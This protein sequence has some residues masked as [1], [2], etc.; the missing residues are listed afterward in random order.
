MIAYLF[1]PLLAA[2]I[3]FLA[4]L[5]FRIFSAQKSYRVPLARNVFIAAIVLFLATVIIV[6]TLHI[7]YRV[8]L[9]PDADDALLI[10]PLYFYPILASVCAAIL[11]LGFYAFAKVNNRFLNQAKWSLGG[12]VIAALITIVVC[13]YVYYKKEIAPESYYDAINTTW[14]TVG[15]VGILVLLFL[16]AIFFGKSSKKSLDSKSV[17]Y[18]AICLAMSFALSYIKL[19]AMPQGGSITLVSLLPLMLYS[20][21]FGLRKGVF[22]GL[23]YGIMQAIQDPWILHPMQFL[24]DYP[25][26]FACIGICSLFT[27]SGIKDKKGIALFAAGSVLAVSLRYMSHVISGIF[28]FSMW[29]QEGYTAVAWGFLYNTFA[30]VDMAIA[31]VVGVLILSNKSFRKILNHVTLTVLSV[32]SSQKAAIVEVKEDESGNIITSEAEID[33]MISSESSDEEKERKVE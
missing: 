24:L 30:F 16:I 15:A 23:I 17:S 31:L 3:L 8:T 11:A 6:V 9:S 7:R 27:Q 32:E 21:M 29:A 10:H 22:I 14:L 4:A 2:T 28:A 33:K 26:A 19:W 1:Y 12:V 25:I 13:M 20:Q 5:S 18:G